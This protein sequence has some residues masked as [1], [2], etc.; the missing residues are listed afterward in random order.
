MLKLKLDLKITLV[1]LGTLSFFIFLTSTLKTEAAEIKALQDNIKT[2]SV[3]IKKIETE[4]NQYRDK[5]TE[6][7]KKSNTLENEIKRIDTTSKKLGADINLTTKQISSTN[8]TLEKIGLEMT[9]NEKLIERNRQ[10]ISETMRQVNFAETENLLEI[11]L[12]HQ[13]LSDFLQETSKL[14]Q[15]RNNLQTKLANLREAQTALDEQRQEKESTKNQLSNLKDRLASQKTIADQNKKEQQVLLSSTKNQENNYQ[16][17][18]AEKLARKKQIEDEIR[19]IEEQIKVQID[20]NSLPESGSGALSWPL[21]QVRITQYFGNTP[22]ASQNPQ[23]YSGNGHNGIDL[24]AQVGTPVF[25]SADG[26]VTGVDNTDKVCPGAS[27]GSWVLIAHPNG[28][29]TLYAHLSHTKVKEGQMVKKGEEIAYTGNTGYT[30]GPHLHLEVLATEAIRITDG[31]NE[32]K[33]KSCIGAV[34]RIPLSGYNGKLNPL[35]YLK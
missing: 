9:D 29:S 8:L 21:S 23:V 12:E 26:R 33:S 22:F 13:N 19:N 11:F 15:L 1:I 34:Y 25:A 10:T 4:I 17:L 20:P 24:A 31:I 2:Y 14:E 18:L 7:Q 27:Y 35:S 5:L 30:T 3:E 6:V 16:K 32:L 28:L